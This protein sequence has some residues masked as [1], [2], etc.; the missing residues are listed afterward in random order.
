M[1]I[2]RETVWSSSSPLHIAITS[3]VIFTTHCVD[4]AIQCA[5]SHIATSVDHA[6]RCP[7]LVV[8][9][10]ELLHQT[11]GVFLGPA[12]HYQNK[13]TENREQYLC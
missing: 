11:G 1:H 2:F 12:T 9:R 6:C 4:L 3:H 8:L 13:Q 5:H 10:T 7:P